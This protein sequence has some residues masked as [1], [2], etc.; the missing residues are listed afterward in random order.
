MR[1]SPRAMG[2]LLQRPDTKPTRRAAG[3]T[4]KCSALAAPDPR[5]TPPERARVR[6]R[7][8]RRRCCAS[9]RSAR[10]CP[11]CPA[12]SPARWAAATSRW[13]SSTG[14][15]AFTAILARPFGGRLADGRGRRPVALVGMALVGAR[16]RCCYFL[17][18]GVAR[19]D[20]LA[21]RPRHR[22]G[23]GVHRRAGVDG[24]P[25]AAR[26][27]RPG[28]RLLRPRRLGRAVVRPAARRGALDARLVRAVW[29]F[30]AVLPLVGA[31]SPRASPTAGAPA[32]SRSGA[33][34]LLPRAA[35]RP[36]FALFLAALGFA[37]LAASSSCTSRSSA[38]GT[39]RR[40][41]RVAT[42]VVVTA[43]RWRGCPTASA[44]AG[45]GDRRGVA[46]R[47]G[48][49]SSRCRP[50][51]RSRSPARWSSAPGSR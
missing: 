7:P 36:G 48:W 14:A 34:G 21:A 9:S 22:A 42:T 18:L 19:A 40:F 35:V 44:R 4:W 38:S 45:S 29:A 24:R 16:R 13:A 8:R 51:A 50:A 6:G 5:P 10:C 25:R 17:P 39:A 41:H 11:S 47:S 49:R 33:G 3:R 46:R 26:P 12:T 23:L 20:P 37:T 32:R 15:F 1:T 27:A 28:H 2:P 30:A 31:R 43:S